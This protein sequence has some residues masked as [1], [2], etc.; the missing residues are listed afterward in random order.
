MPQDLPSMEKTLVFLQ[1]HLSMNNEMKV[2][3]AL[4]YKEF[5]LKMI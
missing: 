1:L 2:M 4:K 3:I 5:K